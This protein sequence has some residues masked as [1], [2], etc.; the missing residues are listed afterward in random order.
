M[1]QFFWSWVFWRLVFCKRSDQIVILR[2][3][4]YITMQVNCKIMRRKMVEY[5]KIMI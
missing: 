3:Q 4:F 2:S 1:K 5:N